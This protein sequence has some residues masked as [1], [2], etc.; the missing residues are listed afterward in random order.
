MELSENLLCLYN[1]RVQE[2]NDSYVIEVPAHEV[3]VG[4]VE[5]G[6][7][8]RVGMLPQARQASTATPE[9]DPA[10]SEPASGRNRDDREPPVDKGEVVEVEIEDIGD[11][12]DG[13]A[14]VGPGY[15]II[16]PETQRGERVAVEISDVRENLAFA[17][18]VDRHD[19]M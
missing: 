6:D 10:E 2:R 15:V 8:Y 4:S 5:P 19:R 12:G 11:Q 1:A 16:V 3:D 9:P 17:E 14:R 18:V 13:I 7:S